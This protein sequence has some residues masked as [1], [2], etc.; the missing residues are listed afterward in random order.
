MHADES[1]ANRGRM[2][3]HVAG[4]TDFLQSEYSRYYGIFTSDQNKLL[5]YW[6]EHVSFFNKQKRNRDRMQDT[7]GE[8][9][10]N[11]ENKPCELTD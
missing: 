4:L 8:G 5:A 2:P 9:F 1:V 7:S 6:K 11:K 3:E 10:K